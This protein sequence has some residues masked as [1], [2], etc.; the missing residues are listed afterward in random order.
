MNTNVLA[1][2]AALSDQDL[3]TRLSALAGKERETM[4]ELLAHL[5][6][7]DDRPDVYAAQGYGSLY[8]YCTQALRFSEDA[9]C[10]RIEAA[11]VCRRFPAIL[12]LLASGEISL[13]SVRLL[14][15]HLTP[16]NHQAVLERAKGRTREEIEVLV[17]TVA[18][19]PDAPTFVRKLPT[20]TVLAPAPAA[21]DATPLSPEPLPTP[22]PLPAPAPASRPIVQPTAPDRYRVQFTI[23]QQTRKKLRR[24]Q[25][26]PLRCRRHN[27]YEADLVFGSRGRPTERAWPLDRA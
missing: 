19:Q 2:A 26:L 9:A 1:T 22:M 18:P 24:L 7:L 5:A 4:A 6:T 23:G 21:Q 10:N 13:T 25:A 17:A 14:R 12:E 27:Q 16:E 20:P 3:L 8:A 15:R 11:R